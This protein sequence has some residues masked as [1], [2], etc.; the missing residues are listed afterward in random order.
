MTEIATLTAEPR[1]YSSA[2]EM[3]STPQQSPLRV[4]PVPPQSSEG[5][6]RSLVKE[7]EIVREERNSNSDNIEVESLV[8]QLDPS[9]AVV[10]PA[11]VTFEGNIKTE[12]RAAVVVNGT[13]NGAITAGEMPVYIANGAAVTGV[14][15]SRAEVVVAGHVAGSGESCI[16]TSGRLMVGSTGRI[17]GDVMFGSLR[18]YDGI[19]AGR[20]MPF[21]ED[22]GAR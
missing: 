2:S 20:I 10:I 19:I 4:V 12:G 13:V 1:S 7:V 9:K 17:D 14:I 16:K 3:A 11:G 8:R 6:P 22:Q 15:S 5:L 18:V 21:A